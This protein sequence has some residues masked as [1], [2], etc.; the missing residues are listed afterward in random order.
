MNRIRKKMKKS[1]STCER[2]RG[3]GPIAGHVH[4]GSVHTRTRA[5]DIVSMQEPTKLSVH[6]SNKSNENTQHSNDSSDGTNT[7]QLKLELL[8]VELYIPNTSFYQPSLRP[9]RLNRWVQVTV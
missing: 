9:Q 2:P 6:K 3:V 1:R 5:R 4:M 8:D 7:K